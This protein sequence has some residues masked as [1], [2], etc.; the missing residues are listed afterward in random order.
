MFS[1]S[2]RG[3]GFLFLFLLSA[4][5]LF[6]IPYSGEDT[7]TYRQPDGST[8]SVKLYGDEYFAYQR[9]LDGLEVILDPT[10]R[11]WCYAKLSADGKTFVSTGV[12]V[13]SRST[14]LKQSRTQALA[15]GAAR[16]DETLPADVVR[17]RVSS[18]LKK[19]RK[20]GKGRPVRLGSQPSSSISSISPAPPARTTVGDFTGLTILVDFPDEPGTVTPAQVDNF[21]N[22]PTGYTEFGN[23]CSVNEYFK[24][25]SNGKLNFC[26][27]VTAYVRMPKPKSYYDDNQP[28]GDKALELV[29]TALNILMEDNFDFTGLSKNAYGEI[30]SV[31]IFYAGTCAS[32][33]SNGLWPHSWSL[34][35]PKTVDAANGV[36]AYTYQ[37]TDIKNELSIGTFIH[38]NGHLTCDFPDLYSYVSSNPSIVGYYSSMSVGSHGGGG[39]HPTSVDPYLKI[40]AGWADVVDVNASSHIRAVAQADRNFFYRFRNPSRSQEYFLIENRNSTGYEGPYGGAAAVNP[41]AGLVVWQVLETGDNTQSS[42]QTNGTY[43]LP[44]EAF[45]VEATPDTSFSPWYSKPTPVA[46]VEDTFHAFRGAN[47]LN[48]ATT[49]ELKF[50]SAS[51]RTTNSNMEIHTYGSTNNAVAYTIGTGSPS[52][53][54]AIG[55]TTTQINANANLGGSPANSVFNIFNAAGGTLSYSITDNVAWLSCSPSSGTATTEA[56]PITVSINASALAPGTHTAT[57]T[58]TAA[59]SSNTPRTIPVSLVVENAPILSTSTS[60]VT[61][62]LWPGQPSNG[63][64][65]GIKNTGGGTMSYTVS[66]SAA[67]LTTSVT[68]GTCVNETDYVFLN[69]NPLG[70]SSGTHDATVTI[71]SAGSSGSPKTVNVSLTLNEGIAV[72]SPNGGEKWVKGA[73]NTIQWQSTESTNVRIELLRNGT[74]NRTIASNTVNDSSHNWTIPVIVQPGD[75][76]RIRVTTIDNAFSDR[77]DAS[78]SILDTLYN[79]NMSANPGWTLDSGWAWGQPTGGAVPN[80]NP[81]P[82]SGY[83]GTHVIGYNLSGAY[84][85]SIVG[86]KWATTPAI[87]CRGRSNVYLSFSRWLGVESNL[88][89]HAY[90]QVSNNGTNWTTIWENGTGYISDAAWVQQAFDITGVAAGHS[91]VRVRWGI[92][93]TDY[94]WAFCGWNID[95]VLITG[96]IQTSVG[97]R[98]SEYR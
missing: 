6:A 30:Y 48:G 36:K 42:I 84:E 76:Y 41:G 94:D 24:I 5:S 4:S 59:G 32:G 72:L 95:D 60:L 12:P 89:D 97:S 37:M 58:I 39:K 74:L 7:F 20:D 56:D 64:S 54:P 91:S 83:S 34:Y 27:T 96:E 49:P 66:D 8:F 86:T 21:C 51:G 80:G 14:D 19:F 25:Q 55:V 3:V 15:A 57:I 50:W 52:A 47:P 82:T 85:N 79:A 13:V 29:D 92:G 90:V 31:N 35:T 98:W 43:S 33:W 67:W 38:E 73:V 65:F 93:P 22:Q 44:Y 40:K 11:F 10:T 45:V 53:T 28:I 26:N 62:S 87:D 2:R 81:D 17:Q 1:A 88:F 77:S 69:F 68:S 61:E 16:K 23:A 71:T 18:A 9:T 78:F 46:N 75:N 70:L 63:K